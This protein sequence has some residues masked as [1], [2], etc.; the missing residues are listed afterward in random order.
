MP[1][2]APERRLAAMPDPQIRNPDFM[3]GMAA[4]II[5]PLSKVF[6]CH[7]VPGGMAISLGP[8]LIE[9]ETN[10][11]TQHQRRRQ[12]VALVE[13]INGGRQ[14][15]IVIAIKFAVPLEDQGGSSV[16]SRP[17]GQESQ[18]RDVVTNDNT[19]SDVCAMSS[20]GYRSTM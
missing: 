17:V 2:G 6:A 20:L 10:H 7:E 14:Q 4:P 19:A 13:C 12:R 18:R 3:I 5:D 11:G 16:M 8:R 15:P 9:R 1:S